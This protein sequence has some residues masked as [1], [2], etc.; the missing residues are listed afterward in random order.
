MATT[1]APPTFSVLYA[2]GDSL[3][4]A[5]NLSLTTDLVGDTTPVSPPYD[6]ESYYNPLLFT[7]V[8]ANVFSNGP[9]WVQDLSRALNL[10]TLSPSLLDGND[11]AYGGAET[12]VT[13][14]NADN[15]ELDAISLPSQL[16]Q[17]EAGVSH[18]SPDAL[19][20]LSIGSNDLLDIL[21]DTTLS[22]TAQTR[23]VQAAVT[24]E[25]NFVDSLVDY[26]AA[27]FLILDVP[28]L[29]ATPDVMDGLANGGD[30]PSAS[31]DTLASSLAATYNADLTSALATV[32]GANVTVVDAYGLID[33]AVA[34]PSAYGL[35]NVTAPVWSGT[36]DSS[37][38]GSLVSTDIATQDQYLFFDHLHPTETGEMAVASLAEADL[39]ATPCF[40]AGTRIATP[41]GAT[42]VQDLRVGD[43]VLLDDGGTASVMWL[44]HRRVDCRRHPRPE[45]VRPVRV[46]AHAFGLGRPAR[47]LMLS[48]DHAV[49]MEGVLLPVR[50]LLTDAT[51]RQEDV[52]D[53]T[54]WH[55]ELARHAVLLA[56]GLPVESYLDTGNR[57]AFANGGAVA[58]AHPNFARAVWERAGCATLVT[59]G[60]ERDTVYRRLVAQAMT[61]GWGKVGAADGGVIWVEP[62]GRMAG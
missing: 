15:P 29:G 2:F 35:T 55:V 3:S 16:V 61:L 59:E 57:A 28:D 9:T 30:T 56:E 1:P 58:M 6:R 49:F 53:V 52:A 39:A 25:V 43:L 13:P 60:K 7:D 20:T 41:K 5:G 45:N 27:N 32:Q 44:G 11:F 48:P 8:S 10:G 12:G 54:Y 31:F 33:D 21:A 26:G 23:D 46:A 40:A 18:P 47:D 42:R 37:S 19:Y 34:S 17:F 36:Y 51:V 50:Y 38:S 62:S 14:Q 24:N 4:D 22:G